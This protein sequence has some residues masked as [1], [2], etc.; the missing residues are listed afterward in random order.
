MP[1]EVKIFSGSL[2]L[3]LTIWWRH[4]HTL[5]SVAHKWRHKNLTP[6]WLWKTNHSMGYVLLWEERME[7]QRPWA[8]AQQLI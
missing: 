2:V 7:Q 6:V 3:D 1:D 5:Y 8:L 4:L